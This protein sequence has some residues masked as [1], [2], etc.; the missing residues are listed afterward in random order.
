MNNLYQEPLNKKALFAGLYPLIQ[1]AIICI[2]KFSPL[3]NLI[4]EK[5]REISGSFYTTMFFLFLAGNILAIAFAIKERD[6]YKRSFI[7]PILLN[8]VSIGCALIPISISI[9]VTFYFP[10]R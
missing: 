7:F 6:R 3:F 4:G 2:V 5:S 8:L 10:W 9:F 1:I